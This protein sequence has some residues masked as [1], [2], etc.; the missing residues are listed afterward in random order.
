MSGFLVDT[1]THFYLPDFDADRLEAEARALDSDVKYMLLPNIDLGSVEALLRTYFSNSERYRPMLGLHPCSVDA[2]WKENWATIKGSWGKA[3]WVAVGEIGLD[4]YWDKT[5]I[6]EQEACLLEQVEWA[7]QQ[8]LPVVL[9]ARDSIDRLTEILG[10]EV[11]ANWG[12][13]FHCFTGDYSQAKRI[14]DLGYYLGIGGVLTYKNSGL[15]DVVSR[16]PL[17]RLLLETDAPYLSPVPYRGKRNEPSF[18]RSTALQLSESMGIGY[19]ELAEQ[20]S[21]NADTLFSLNLYAR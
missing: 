6:A 2:N 14:L 11:V 18:L 5:Y 8:K 9:H 3:S 1:H 20:T 7:N 10:G 21:R 17:D 4:F 19:E 12:A 16:L 13:V 15:R